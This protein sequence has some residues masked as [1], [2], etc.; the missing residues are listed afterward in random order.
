[1]KSVGYTFS[2]QLLYIFIIVRCGI[3][4]FPESYPGLFFGP[5]GFIEDAPSYEFGVSNL[6]KKKRLTV[7]NHFFFFFFE[8]SVSNSNYFGSEVIEIEREHTI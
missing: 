5:G 7:K 3:Q 2:K 1:M 6:E 4:K 8:N